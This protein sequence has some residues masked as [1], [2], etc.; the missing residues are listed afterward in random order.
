MGGAIMAL[1]VIGMYF[2]DKEGG[3]MLAV[4]AAA[5]FVLALISRWY[6]EKNRSDTLE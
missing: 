3:K 6:L 5:A 2:I 4:L 1:S